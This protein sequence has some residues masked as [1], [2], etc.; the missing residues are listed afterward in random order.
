MRLRLV[1]LQREAAEVAAERKALDKCV[2]SHVAE[3][4]RMQVREQ[5]GMALE[6]QRRSPPHSII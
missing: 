6:K 1:L 2:Q 5:N 3:L 4:R